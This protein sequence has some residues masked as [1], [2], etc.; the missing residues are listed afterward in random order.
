M[1]N[2]FYFEN[3]AVYEI[4]WENIFEPDKPQM[5]IWR[6][7]ISCCIPKTKTPTQNMNA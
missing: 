5:T 1:F 7:R 2:K 6:M 3:G 4:R